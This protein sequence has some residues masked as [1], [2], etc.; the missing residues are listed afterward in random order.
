VYF[1]LLEVQSVLLTSVIETVVKTAS[2]LSRQFVGIHCQF[3]VDLEIN[4][5]IHLIILLNKLL[6]HL[7]LEGLPVVTRCHFK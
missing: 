6:H 5:L 2:L 1:G 7:L 4:V 3:D